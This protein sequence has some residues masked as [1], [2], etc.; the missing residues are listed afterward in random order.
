MVMVSVGNPSEVLSRGEEDTTRIFEGSRH[1]KWRTQLTEPRLPYT[2]VVEIVEGTK[3]RK[4]EDWRRIVRKGCV[5]FRALN[6]PFF[7]FFLFIYLT[8]FLSFS[9]FIQTLGF[10]SCWPFSSWYARMKRWIHC[11]LWV[12]S[13]SPPLTVGFFVYECYLIDIRVS[14]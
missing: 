9:L 2:R 4:E 3:K 6:T 14:R 7:L 11:S 1:R 5:R 13:W 8:I 10:T 12:V